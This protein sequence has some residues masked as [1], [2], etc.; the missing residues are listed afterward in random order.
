MDL[1]AFLHD[2]EHT[3]VMIDAAEYREL[4]AA[5]SRL[6]RHGSAETVNQLHQACMER[7]GTDRSPSTQRIQRFRQKVLG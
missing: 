6:L 2:G 3:L 7:F 1:P 5:R 4:V